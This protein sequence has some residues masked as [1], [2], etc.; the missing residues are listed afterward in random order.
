MKNIPYIKY[1]GV[2]LLSAVALVGCSE[3]ELSE[4]PA[5]GPLK[6]NL[7]WPEGESVAG[8]RLWLYDNSGSLHTAILDC[9]AEGHECRVPAGTYTL[10]VANADCTNAD[11]AKP[12]SWQEHCMKVGMDDATRTLRHVDDVFC[13]GVTEVT[14]TRGNRPAEVTLC[15]ENRVRKLHFRITPEHIDDVAGLELRLTGIVP[16]VRLLDGEDA[17]E[18]T[19]AVLAEAHA[20]AGGLYTADMSVFGWRGENIVTT[21]VRHTDGHTVTTEPEDIGTQLQA[22][23]EEGGTVNITLTLPDGGEIELS[24]AVDAWESGSGSGTVI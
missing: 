15:P 19:G 21:T 10:L 2:V 22:L 6:I 14:V 16:S 13:T 11:C 17:G 8:A 5:D 24:V 4:R 12:E 23:P 3:R 7:V 18:A 1:V 9:A 20:D